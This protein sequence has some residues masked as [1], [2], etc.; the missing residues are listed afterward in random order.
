M[1]SS[2]RS[3]V[4]PRRVARGAIATLA[5]LVFGLSG[6]ACAQPAAPGAEVAAILD[7]LD[8]AGR[9]DLAQSGVVVET[10][11]YVCDGER[12]EA[13]AVRPQV[14]GRHPGLLLIPGYQRTARDYLPLALRLAR[15]GYACVAVSQR[16]F[17]RSTGAP[18][19]VG[20]ATMRAI[21]LGFT[22]LRAA[23]FVDSMR[24]GVFGYSRGAIAASL[25]AT[26]RPD[27]RAAVFGGGIYDMASAY[28]EIG[29]PVIRD[30]MNRESGD[31]TAAF[32]E[33][34]SL[35]HMDRLGCPVLILHGGRDA[36]VPVAQARMLEARLKQLHKDYE[37][38][39]YED[40]D[41]NLGLPAILEATLDFFDRRLKGASTR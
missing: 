9:V 15:A 33:R 23:T 40:R 17:G 5:A 18:D 37:I 31:T 35:G 41:H 11:D 39:I 30:N 19:F 25:L 7:S 16:G 6:H 26:R 32:A 8:R 24:V 27:V 2:S 12:V 21:D 10:W 36:N 14:P 22:R 28:H 29:S 13:I 1:T 3:A 34:S 20:P 38:R 4:R